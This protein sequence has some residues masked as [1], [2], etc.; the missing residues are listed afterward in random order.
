[1][2]MS[3]AA[4]MVFYSYYNY[5]LMNKLILCYFPCLFPFLLKQWKY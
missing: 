1:M 2:A 5:Y 4:Y 3:K